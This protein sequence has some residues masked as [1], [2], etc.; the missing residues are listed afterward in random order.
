MPNILLNGITVLGPL[1]ILVGK[2]RVIVCCLCAR[3]RH[4]G[5]P[6]VYST[7][8][9]PLSEDQGQA[10]LEVYRYAGTG[11]DKASGSGFEPAKAL[12]RGLLLPPT[13]LP[14]ETT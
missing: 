4:S 2:W 10:T 6:P 8:L 12:V 9:A 7:R 11:R 5:H 3:E 14:S 13:T 1:A